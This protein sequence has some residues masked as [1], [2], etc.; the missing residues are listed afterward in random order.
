MDADDEDWSWILLLLRSKKLRRQS[1]L[2]IIRG[3]VQ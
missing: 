1:V 2:D 3:L